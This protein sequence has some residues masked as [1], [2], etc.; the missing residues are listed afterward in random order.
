MYVSNCKPIFV[1]GNSLYKQGRSESFQNRGVN[2]LLLAKR[3]SSPNAGSY[4]KLGFKI[5]VFQHTSN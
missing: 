2:E 1:I 5:L 4:A 3:N